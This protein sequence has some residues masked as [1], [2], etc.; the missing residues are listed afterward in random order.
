MKKKDMRP[1]Y[2]P[3]RARDLS[4]ASVSGFP[5]PQG[6][7]VDGSTIVP[8]GICAPHG[9]VPGGGAGE[10]TPQGSGQD[11]GTCSTGGAAIEGCNSGSVFS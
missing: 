7:C 11:F 2:D 10:C 1:I 3:P 5:V 9:P 6:M 8:A 4:G